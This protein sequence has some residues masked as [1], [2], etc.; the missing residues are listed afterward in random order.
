VS[1]I[2]FD[3]TLPQE[4]DK[5]EEGGDGEEEEATMDEADEEQ[6]KEGETRSGRSRS[7]CLA[8]ERS[9]TSKCSPWE[10]YNERRCEEETQRKKDLAALEHGQ[11]EFKLER[12]EMAKM[13]QTFKD[14]PTTC[15]GEIIATMQKM[16]MI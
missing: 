10:S 15:M 1:S 13:A 5:D 6:R 12:K 16:A 9:C 11:E 2:T 4:V 3:I 14:S 8:L 7:E